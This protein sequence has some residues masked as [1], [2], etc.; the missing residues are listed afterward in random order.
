M[1]DAPSSMPKPQS[2]RKHRATFSAA[3]GDLQSSAHLASRSGPSGA[4]CR[5]G[6]WSLM[7]GEITEKSSAHGR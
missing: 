5:Q 2:R 1:L 4:V 7:F 3:T 6:R